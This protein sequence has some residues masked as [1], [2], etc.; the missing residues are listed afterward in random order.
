V[1]STGTITGGAGTTAEV[2]S[3]PALS[4]SVDAELEV[5]VLD[6]QAS[7]DVGAATAALDDAVGGTTA[8]LGVR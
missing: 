1:Q 2:N 3:E 8:A 4:T 7:A 6:A 5:G